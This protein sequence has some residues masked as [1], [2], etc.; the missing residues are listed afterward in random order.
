MKKLYTIYLGKNI[1]QDEIDDM[2]TTKIWARGGML[3]YS[4]AKANACIKNLKKYDFEKQNKKFKIVEL[5]K[6]I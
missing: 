5:I 6:S 2:N 1:W 3:W 4:K